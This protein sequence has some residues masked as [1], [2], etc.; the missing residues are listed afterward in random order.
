M[1]E[2]EA[3]LLEKEETLLQEA[4]SRCIEKEPLSDVVITQGVVCVLLA[5][6]L[7]VMNLVEPSLS[8]QLLERVRRLL[9]WAFDWNALLDRLPF[10]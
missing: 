1:S 9:V 2:E 3:E 6:G 7:A 4:A 5:L 8:A 10:L